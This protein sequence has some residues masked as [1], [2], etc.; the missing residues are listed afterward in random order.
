MGQH[1]GWSLYFLDDIRDGECLSRSG[2]TQQSLVGKTRFQ[3]I[4]ELFDCRRLIA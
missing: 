4:D 2:D 3:A 1:H